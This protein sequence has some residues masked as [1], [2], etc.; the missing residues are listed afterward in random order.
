VICSCPQPGKSRIAAGP[1]GRSVA[2]DRKRPDRVWAR[3]P[4]V[5]DIIVCG[6]SVARHGRSR[7]WAPRM[8][9]A[10]PSLLDASRRHRPGKAAAGRR[11][12][13]NAAQDRLSQLNVLLQL[14]HLRSYEPVKRAR[15]PS[16]P[17]VRDRRS[18]G[19]RLGSGRGRFPRHRRGSRRA[20]PAADRALKRQALPQRTRISSINSWFSNG[21]R[22]N[23]SAPP[24]G[25]LDDV[26]ARP[27]GDDEHRHSRVR[28]PFFSARRDRGLGSGI[29][30]SSRTRFGRVLELLQCRRRRWSRRWSRCPPALAGWRGR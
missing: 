12:S 30:I 17:V 10:A 24:R 8:S 20:D 18:R 7:T 11:R 21:L 27:R 23:S 16:M 14:E 25:A 9:V 22:M 26:L 15:P 29:A 13:G 19:P 3:C 4:E 2:D 1:D 6:H 28:D 5:R